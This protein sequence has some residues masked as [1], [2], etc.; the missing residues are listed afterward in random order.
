[1]CVLQSVSTAACAPARRTCARRSSASTQTPSHDAALEHAS[2]GPIRTPAPCRRGTAGH[3]F[4]GASRPPPSLASSRT[5]GQNAAPSKLRREARRTADR[6]QTRPTVRATAGLRIRGRAAVGAVQG[7]GVA[8]NLEYLEYP[9]M[10]LLP[11]SAFHRPSRCERH[12]DG[13]DGLHQG[14]A[15]RRH[16]VDRRLAI[17]RRSFPDDDKAIKNG[18]PLIVRESQQVQF[19]YLGKFG[20]SPFGPGKHTLTPTTSRAHAAE[21][22]R[23]TVQLALQGRRLLPRPRGCSRATSGGPPIRS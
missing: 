22:R 11:S 19:V 23:S 14:R 1:M 3:G 16:R 5:C 4:G 12:D 7:I 2:D 9:G 13:S 8:R 6:R 21:V 18:A 15:D 10:E 20:D 17:P